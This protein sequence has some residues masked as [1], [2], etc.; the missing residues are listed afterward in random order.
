ML[1][2]PLFAGLAA[3]IAFGSGARLGQDPPEPTRV[4]G[5]L[6]VVNDDI[7][8]LSEIEFVRW[9]ESRAGNAIDR[10]RILSERV[11]SLL[12]TQAG[13][14]MGFDPEQVQTL[15]DERFEHEVERRGGAVGASAFFVENRLPPGELREFWR[16]ELYAQAWEDAVTGRRASAGGRPSVDR[17]VRPGQRW[18]FYRML[19]DSS[20]PRERRMLGELPERVAI[21]E[22]ILPTEEFGGVDSALELARELL[23]SY[24]GERED[25]D[26]LV[27]SYGAVKQGAG[28][29]EPVPVEGLRG[30]SESRH[31]DTSLYEFAR[32]AAVDGVSEALLG[33]KP[34][35][36][37]QAVFVYRLHERLPAVGPRRLLDPSL[38]QDLDRDL[39]ERI[40]ALR[41]SM[42]LERTA[43]AAWIWPRSL[44]SGSR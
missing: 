33:R 6:A 2:P 25:F 36:S 34:G 8:T 31:G 27:L 1:S 20:N 19:E 37:H 10:E 21:Q 28:L 41:I 4:D 35:T 3:L 17:Y 24:G 16:R 18:A 29:S 15:L 14:D 42:E 9:R 43:D 39:S 38:R 23:R 26:A 13:E 30:M 44:L 40:D 11:S 7:I 22:L 5:V 32:T 12:K